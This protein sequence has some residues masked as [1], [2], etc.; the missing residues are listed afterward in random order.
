M[1]ISC[2]FSEFARPGWPLHDLCVGDSLKVEGHS[3]KLDAVLARA[4]AVMFDDVGDTRDTATTQQ[5]DRH[6]NESMSNII[7]T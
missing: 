6:Y 4:A 3:S 5:L 7:I 1:T 2:V